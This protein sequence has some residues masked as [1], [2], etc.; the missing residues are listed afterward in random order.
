MLPDEKEEKELAQY[1][2]TSIFFSAVFTDMAAALA[3]VI[4]GRH[5]HAV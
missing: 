3:L 5:I 2:D 4:S 1:G